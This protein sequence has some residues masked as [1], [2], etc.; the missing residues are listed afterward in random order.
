MAT[1]ANLLSPLPPRELAKIRQ[2]AKTH[3]LAVEL[4]NPAGGQYIG[5]LHV[6]T[7]SLVAQYVGNKCL[8]IHRK[9]AL[10]SVA[11]PS[12]VSITYNPGARRPTIIR[13]R[14]TPRGLRTWD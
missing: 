11:P 5:S 6:Q 9:A 10:G 4:P 12:A 1:N 14:A 8:V 13:L 2:Y 7:E 3:G